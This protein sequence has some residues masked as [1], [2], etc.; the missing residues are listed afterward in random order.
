MNG[1]VEEGLIAY[2]IT[3]I[4]QSD[5]IKFCVEFGAGDGSNHS[6]TRNLIE[7]HDWKAFLIEASSS[8][9]PKLLEKYKDSES[10]ITK[11]SFI[12][13]ENILDLFKNGNVPKNLG[14]LCVDIDGNDYYVLEKIL[15]NYI[16]QIICVEF[17]SSYGPNTEFKINYDPSFVW[18]GD[19]Y[20]GASFASFNKLCEQFGYSLIHCTNGGDN[21]FFVKDK[22]ASKFEKWKKSPEEYYQLPQYGRRGRAINGKGHPAS[23]KNTSSAQRLLFSLRYFAMNPPRKIFK[24]INKLKSNP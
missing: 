17:N 24:I 11:N 16:P 12:T 19:D 18:S 3:K 10:I 2:I 5:L 22:F 23:S 13:Q 6:F 21:L 14:F 7:N 20:F 8:L 15:E 9:A 4:G 1:I